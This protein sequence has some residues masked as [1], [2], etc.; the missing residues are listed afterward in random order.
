MLA[1]AG[2][3]SLPAAA[4][5][6]AE[7]AGAIAVEDDRV[8]FRH[9]LLRSLAYRGPAA[10][11]RRRAHG[12]LASSPDRRA[13]ASR[14][15]AAPGTWLRPRSR[16]TRRWPPSSRPRPSGFAQP[17]RL[18]RGGLRLRARRG[19]DAGGGPPGRAARGRR[20]GDAAGRPPRTRPRAARRSRGA[21]RGSGAARRHRVQAGDARGV[22]RLGRGR[23]SALRA[24][25]RRGDRPGPRRPGAI[26]RGRRR[27]SRPATPRPRSPAP[28][29]PR[30]CSTRVSERT[31]CTVRE[32]LGAVLVLRG[33]PAE[34]APL[35]REAAAWF[36]ANEDLPSRDYVAQALL[37]VED[38][39]LVAP[40]A[41]AAAR[42]RAPRRATCARSRPRSRSRP[43][44]STAPA[45]GARR[46]PPP[47]SPRASRP[48]RELT[49]QLAYSLGVLAI[50]EAARGDAASAEHAAQADEI[51]ARNRLGVIAEYTG[52]ARGLD[53]LGRGRPHEALA[54]L[55]A[56][57][58]RVARTGRRQ[59]GVLQ[60]EADLLEAAVRAERLEDARRLRARSASARRDMRGPPRWRR[61]S[62]G[63][64]AD[65]Y[66]PHFEQALGHDGGPFEAART[67][68][69]LGPAAAPRRA[70]GR[71]ARAA[72]RRA[73]GLPR[74]RRG[75]VGRRGRARARAPPARSCAAAR[76]RPRRS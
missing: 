29:A 48:T 47:R 68:S 28:S 71:S 38:Y 49:V 17:R 74:A 66:R 25:R 7:R 41:R 69:V 67:H 40:P 8:R 20:R 33:R 26:A 30:S 43:S 18:P 11:E 22:A 65:D 55:E 52:A 72:A 16:R 63:L 4:F 21:R 73:R 57:A 19:A 61:G 1:A 50:V 32:T 44:S 5:A 10:E 12:A 70:A 35:L 54:H 2:R 51:A 53:A 76:P 45:T 24:P 36:E 27:R 23:R 58:E 46:T 42:P 6:E 56:V 13:R 64:I 37:W 31:A 15:S 62:R 9:P 59:P 34:G 75:A 39:A 14:A 3:L 60:W